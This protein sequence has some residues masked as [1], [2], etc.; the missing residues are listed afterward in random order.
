MALTDSV[1]ARLR[2]ADLKCTVVQVQ[3]KDPNFRT[4]QKQCTL[5]RATWLR[6]ELTAHAMD[7]IRAAC[8]GYGSGI[9]ALT[10]TAS[11]LVSPGDTEEQLDIFPRPPTPRTGRK[12]WSWLWRTSAASTAAP[13]SVW[14]ATKMRRSARIGRESIE[15]RFQ[16]LK[17]SHFLRLFSLTFPFGCDIIL[18]HYA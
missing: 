7:L 5:K 17:M 14:A 4:V 11:G 1:A 8:G 6:Q 9:R 13:A 18:R 15:F 10:V 12:A 16:S 2:E 3:V